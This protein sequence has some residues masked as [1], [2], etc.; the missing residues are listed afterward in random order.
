MPEGLGVVFAPFQLSIAK[1]MPK[2]MSAFKPLLEVFLLQL[3]SS[4][5]YYIS[6]KIIIQLSKIRGLTARTKHFLFFGKFLIFFSSFSIEIRLSR[7]Y[8]FI[9]HKIIKNRNKKSNISKNRGLTARAKHFFH[10]Q[11][12]FDFL[13]L[14]LP[15]SKFDYFVFQF[16]LTKPIFQKTKQNTKNIFTLLRNLKTLFSSA[17]KTRLL[18]FLIQFNKLIFQKIKPHT[19]ILLI[20]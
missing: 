20:F 8:F 11:K 6:Q 12:L 18:R 9:I 19:K 3:F 2:K 14:F 1:T 10:F 4:F 13:L 16:I 5:L 17:I 15:L 7:I